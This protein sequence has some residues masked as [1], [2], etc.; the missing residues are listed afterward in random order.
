MLAST[1]VRTIARGAVERGEHDL[2]ARLR[3]EPAT[4]VLAVRGDRVALDDA[5][6]GL[7]LVRPADVIDDAAWAFLGRLDDGSALLL[8]AL[9][10]EGEIP[11]GW[12]ALRDV[13]H[14]L[15]DPEE[16]GLLSAGV[17]LGRWL[18]DASFCPACGGSAE[19]TMSGWARRCRGCGREH[20]P[21]T[22][23]AVIVG[24]TSADDSRLLLGANVA[25]RGRMF[26]CFAGFVEAGESAEQTIRRE[27]VE[28]AGVDVRDVRYVGSQAWPYPRSLML[29]YLATA[30]DETRVRPD[31]EE[32][33]A[34]RWFTR[35]EVRRAFAGEGDVRLPGASSIAHRI[36]RRWC[37]GPEA[38]ET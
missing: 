36:I 32:I 24:I 18:R 29:G 37:D 11:D 19:I 2:V 6:R 4:R 1:E 3:T 30:V 8:A 15:A 22:D 26:S 5:R 16:A 27:L 38:D 13:S 34:A 35:E 23:P 21:R 20:F 14:L 31:G 9:D 7:A 33:I 12:G 28:E 10:G 25:W 17:A